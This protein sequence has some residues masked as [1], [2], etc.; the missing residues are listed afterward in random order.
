MTAKIFYS[1]TVTPKLLK[2]VRRPIVA[3]CI[4]HR[5]FCKE[6][7]LR[8]HHVCACVCVCV[9]ICVF[10]L[11]H[12]EPVDRHVNIIVLQNTHFCFFLNEVLSIIPNMKHLVKCLCGESE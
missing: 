3:S 6:T 7:C 10:L 8:Y 9:C 1:C 4:M 2:R 12:F 11:I 5:L